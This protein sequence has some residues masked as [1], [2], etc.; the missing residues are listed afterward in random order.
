MTNVA[1]GKRGGNE[2]KGVPPSGRRGG[3]HQ[4]HRK[5]GFASRDVSS[6]QS[7][8]W[9]IKAVRRKKKKSGGRARDMKSKRME[10][11]L[12]FFVTGVLSG[13]VTSVLPYGERPKITRS[14]LVLEE[15]GASSR[16]RSAR[17]PF[18]HKEEGTE[19]IARE[20]D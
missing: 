15:S 11:R 8:D 20:K 10:E 13:K 16:P 1:S 6:I 2:G 18:S 9:G 3:P 14:G 4:H 5:A 12:G 7:H 17:M 19:T